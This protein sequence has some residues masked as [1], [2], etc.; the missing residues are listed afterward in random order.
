MVADIKR[1]GKQ[2]EFLGTIARRKRKHII[3]LA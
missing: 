1:K 2:V 3:E